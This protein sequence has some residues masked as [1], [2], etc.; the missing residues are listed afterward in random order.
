MLFFKI[1]INPDLIVIY[2]T[3]D[4]ENQWFIDIPCTLD[5]RIQK[6]TAY[7]RQSICRTMRIV[8]PIPQ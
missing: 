3:T 5:F 7:G 2:D 6:N 1:F 8:A 4:L